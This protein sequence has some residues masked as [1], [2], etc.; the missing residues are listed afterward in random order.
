MLNALRSLDGC[1]PA[2]SSASRYA[3][4]C[5]VTTNLLD[6]VPAEPGG[7]GSGVMSGS[8]PGEADVLLRSFGS[9]TLD[10]RP[11]VAAQP[12]SIVAANATVTAV[13][14]RVARLAVGCT[15]PRYRLANAAPVRRRCGLLTRRAHLRRLLDGRGQVAGHRG[16][17]RS[18]RGP[19]VIPA[20]WEVE[21]PVVAA[22]R[23]ILLVEQPVGALRLVGVAD[24]RGRVASRQRL[25]AE[26][27][28]PGVVVGEQRRMHPGVVP[29]PA[30][31]LGQ[32]P[33][34]AGVDAAE[35]HQA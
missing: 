9:A 7:A 30:A 23:P 35:A 18:P 10:I 21:V 22:D 11:S 32:A 28:D 26:H 33:H 4:C 25:R 17:L 6:A 8:S 15:P 1:T 3:R 12:D 19:S 27:P 24:H 29:L 2:A 20:S 16:Q 13:E 14:H 31:Q 5:R 34:V